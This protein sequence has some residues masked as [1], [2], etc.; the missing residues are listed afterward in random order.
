[1][2]HADLHVNTRMWCTLPARPHMHSL[3]SRNTVGQLAQRAALTDRETESQ[4]IWSL[5]T[6]EAQILPMI[7][8]SIR[9]LQ[10]LVSTV[11]S[12]V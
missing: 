12:A 9:P 6:F 5:V 7:H 4:A 10:H 2:S 3:S 8:S 11:L 1:M